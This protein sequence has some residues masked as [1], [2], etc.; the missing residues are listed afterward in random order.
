MQGRRICLS[1][2]QGE[3]IWLFS[4]LVGAATETHADPKAVRE[5][6]LLLG[7]NQAPFWAGN[8]RAQASCAFSS[9]SVLRVSP[10]P[11]IGFALTER[12]SILAKM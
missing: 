6:P 11:V 3:S 10:C 2:G 5:P 9:E 8:H 12:G 4:S 1:A 7:L